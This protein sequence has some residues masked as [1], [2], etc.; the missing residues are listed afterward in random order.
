ML[1]FVMK[2]V[3]I[4][5]LSLHWPSISTSVGCLLHHIP[6]ISMLTELLIG[7]LWENHQS[8]FSNL[9][10]FFL[11]SRAESYLN[12][13]IEIIPEDWHQKFV[14]HS[15]TYPSTSNL[16]YLFYFRTKF[17]SSSLNLVVSQI[18]WQVSPAAQWI[19][20]ETNDSNTGNI[21]NT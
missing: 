19:N 1:T 18:T 10:I 13:L 20:F 2:E 11:Q 8:K 9:R 16:I 3:L 7:Y 21:S 6:L 12:K 5:Q 14:S 17:Y 4:I 15:L